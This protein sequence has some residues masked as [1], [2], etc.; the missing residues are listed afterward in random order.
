MTAPSGR[1]QRRASV[2][3]VCVCQGETANAQLIKHATLRHHPILQ[4][5]LQANA[6]DDGFTPSATNYDT[7]HSANTEKTQR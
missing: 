4:M 5:P 1:H 7:P 6:H 2:L 3:R